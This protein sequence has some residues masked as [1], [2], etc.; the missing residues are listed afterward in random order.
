MYLEDKAKVFGAFMGAVDVEQLQTILE[1][2]QKSAAASGA[3]AGATGAGQNRSMFM[4]IYA[5][6]ARGHMAR[7]GTPRS[8]SSRWSRRRTPTT[9]RSI[10]APSSARR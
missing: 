6:A 2:L 7:Y 1:G 4:D 10:R 5:A 8:S 9:A 3:T